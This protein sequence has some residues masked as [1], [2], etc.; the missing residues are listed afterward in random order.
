[1]VQ[2]YLGTIKFLDRA[3]E[4]SYRADP[5]IMLHAVYFIF[6]FSQRSQDLSDR[7]QLNFHQYLRNRD[8]WMIAFL[9]FWI[10]VCEDQE[11]WKTPK[12]TENS[13]MGLSISAITP[14]QINISKSGIS[15]WHLR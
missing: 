4:L 2:M 14:K 6:L 3:I 8:H 11:G 13:H 9:E 7:F 10:S 15:A 12:T 5:Q 1:M